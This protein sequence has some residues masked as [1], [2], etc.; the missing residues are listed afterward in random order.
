VA[1]NAEPHT[2]APYPV[3]GGPDRPG[4]RMN[5]LTPQLLTGPL[6]LIPHSNHDSDAAYAD[7]ISI[8]SYGT[9]PAAIRPRSSAEC[10]DQNVAVMFTSGWVIC[11]VWGPRTARRD[12]RLRVDW[13][14]DARVGGF[15]SEVTISCFISSMVRA[16]SNTNANEVCPQGLSA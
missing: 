2:I 15:R 14:A 3:Q 16:R 6:F 11:F 12:A 10:D 4:P 8:N 13:G 7:A 5:R 1:H 9:N